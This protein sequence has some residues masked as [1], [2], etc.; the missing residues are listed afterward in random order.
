MRERGRRR[1]RGGTA[2]FCGVT[3]YFQGRQMRSDRGRTSSLMMGVLVKL[4]EHDAR[5]ERLGRKRDMWR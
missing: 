3:G 4:R 2:V 1:R 5:H